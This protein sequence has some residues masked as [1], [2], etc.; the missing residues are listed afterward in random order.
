M[1][2]IDFIDAHRARFVD[3]LL[4]WVRVPSISSDPSRASTIW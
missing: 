2:E 3:E 1:K 4:A